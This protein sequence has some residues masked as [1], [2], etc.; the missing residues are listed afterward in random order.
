[1]KKEVITVVQET[2]PD[3]DK[4]VESCPFKDVDTGV[5]EGSR[6]CNSKTSYLI[7]KKRTQN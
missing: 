6:H 7:I 4:I 5:L 2:Y 1:M 3:F